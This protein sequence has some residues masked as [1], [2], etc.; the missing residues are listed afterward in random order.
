M[1]LLF[2]IIQQLMEHQMFYLFWST[3]QSQNRLCPPPPGHHRAFDFV[4][5]VW[6]NSLVCWQFRWSNAPPASAS[7]ASI[8]HPQAIFQ[9]C[10]HFSTCLFKFKY[11]T[12]TTETHPK[13]RK[14]VLRRILHFH[15][16][17]HF[18]KPTFNRPFQRLSNAPTKEWMKEQ[19]LMVYRYEP[20]SRLEPY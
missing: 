1:E 7:N 18:R 9:N 13:S 5:K 20:A 2:I 6:S 4:E 15:K 16:I 10:S 12:D 8:P 11:R 19:L 14:A 3:S 17:V